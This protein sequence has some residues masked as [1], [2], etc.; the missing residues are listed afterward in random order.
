M[1]FFVNKEKNASGNLPPR[2]VSRGG[3]TERNNMKTKALIEI[4]EGDTAA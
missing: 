1:N 4:Y 3:F 2:L